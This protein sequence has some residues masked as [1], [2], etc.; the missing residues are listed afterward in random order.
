MTHED[1]GEK[2]LKL[3]MTLLLFMKHNQV[4]I[5]LLHEILFVYDNL[6]W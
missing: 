2:H 3:K 5:N 6:N 1:L 4:M